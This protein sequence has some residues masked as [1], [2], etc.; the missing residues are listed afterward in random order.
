MARIVATIADDGGSVAA[1]RRHGLA[2]RWLRSANARYR[3]AAIWPR[4]TLALGQNRSAAAAGRDAGLEQAVDVGLERRVVVVDGSGRARRAAAGRAPGPGS[5]AIWARVT[6]LLRAV[7]AFAPHPPVIPAAARRLM[8]ASPVRPV[9]VVEEVLVGRPGRCI[10]RS[11][12]I[13]IWTRVTALPVQ[14]MSRSQP[15]VMPFRTPRRCGSRT[16]MPFQSLTQPR[17]EVDDRDRR[18]ARAEL[19]LRPAAPVGLVGLEEPVVRVGHRRGPCTSR[20]AGR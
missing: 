13:A 1:S 3:N 18:P 17:P 16:S 5:A 6:V 15:P 19:H 12:N 14:N 20:P 8:L 2:L 7:A 4:V 9:V 10:A 11:M